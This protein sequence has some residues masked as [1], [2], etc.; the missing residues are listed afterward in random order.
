MSLFLSVSHLDFEYESAPEALFR[1]FS[2]QFSPGWTGIAGANG[3]GK[4]TLLKLLAGLLTPDRGG[5]R[6]SGAPVYCDQDAAQPPPLLARLFDSHD[7]C[8]CRLRDHLGLAPEMVSRW[9][10]L[11]FGERKKLQIACALFERPDILCLDEPTNH[12]DGAGREL[13]IR[14]LHG[15]NGIGLLVSHDRELLDTLCRQCLLFESRGPILRAGGIT[16]ARALARSEQEHQLEQQQQLQRE[17][18]RN[19]QELQRRREKE[20]Q[21]RNRDCKR[22]LDRHDHDGKGKIDAA[23]VTGRDRRQGDL[24]GLQARNVER[25]S[26]QLAAAGTVK[27]A[28]Y[29][30][31]IP[32]GSYAQ[33]NTLLELPEQR[34]PLGPERFLSTP[35]LRMASRD[36]IALTGANGGGKSSLLHRIIPALKLPPEEYLYMPQE[37]SVEQLETIHRTLSKLT[38]DEFSRVMNV[39]ASLGSRPESLLNAADCSPGEWRKLFFGLGALHPIHLI[40]MD[41]P[42]NHLDLPSIECLEAALCQCQC[43]LLLVSHDQRFLDATCDTHWQIRDGVLY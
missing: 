1:D 42:T 39:V 25:L 19:K 40:V 37:F 20:Q 6:T 13:L 8:A 15:Y 32:Y 16:A 38:R 9:H 24:A 35:P 23:R 14:E 43:A 2:M 22:K 36:R 18:K 41:E 10:R 28:H 4:S 3:C 29:S 26:G 11:S 30:L 5:I 34:I 31:K 33:K 21:A 12:L 27:I 7:S 17:W